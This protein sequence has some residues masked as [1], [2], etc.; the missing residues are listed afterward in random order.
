[1]RATTHS[2]HKPVNQ[3]NAGF[4]A[5]ILNS[6]REMAA[7]KPMLALMVAALAVSAV[8]AVVAVIAGSIA[9]VKG[10]VH[11]VR[12]HHQKASQGAAGVLAWV[13]AHKRQVLI[14]LALCLLPDIMAATPGFIKAFSEII[15]M[16]R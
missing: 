3:A 11:V 1:M 7:N 6:L 4:E 8:A 9:L 2:A 12:N 13:L 15:K 14:G 10:V 16:L 5:S